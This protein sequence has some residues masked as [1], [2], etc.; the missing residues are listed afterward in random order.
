MAVPIL[1]LAIGCL[2][3]YF[4]V[5]PT[6]PLPREYIGVASLAGL[7]TLFGGIRAAL[8]TRF[9]NELFLTGFVFNIFLALG[10]VYLGTKIGVEMYL[11]AVVTLGGRLFLNLSIIRRHYLSKL[12]DARDRRTVE[13][14]QS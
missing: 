11:A 5:N 10:L 1:A 3:A 14:N 4:A 7:D 6:A 2:L 8:E 12:A 13:A 9:R